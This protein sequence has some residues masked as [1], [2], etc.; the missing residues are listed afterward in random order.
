[1]TLPRVH[2]YTH[3][4]THTHTHTDRE[5]ETETETE[6]ENTHTLTAK[7]DTVAG[8][9]SWDAFVPDFRAAREPMGVSCVGL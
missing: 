4:Q 1:M 6:T 8:T 2:T 9:A 3:T 7:L 5:T